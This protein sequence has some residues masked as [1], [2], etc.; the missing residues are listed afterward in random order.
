MTELDHKT[1]LRISKELLKAA[2]IK[3][4]EEEVHLSE[5]IRAFLRA[6]TEDEIELPEVKEIDEA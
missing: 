1:T 3:A 2:R 6:W 5:A 4:I